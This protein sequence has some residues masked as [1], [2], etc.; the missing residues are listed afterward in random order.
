MD[1]ETE[2]KYLN[3]LKQEIEKKSIKKYTTFI[4]IV[5]MLGFMVN[6]GLGNPVGHAIDSSIKGNCI[7]E[8]GTCSETPCEKGYIE[9]DFFCPENEFCCKKNNQ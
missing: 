2:T 4:L 1:S 3:K 6:F 5:L 9:K 7:T 8:G